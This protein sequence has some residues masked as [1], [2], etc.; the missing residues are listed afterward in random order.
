MDATDP[1]NSPE[2][3]AVD[4]A[5]VEPSARALNPGST[6]AKSR[7]V[8]GECRGELTLQP[9]EAD[10]I[11]QLLS[12][13]NF[14]FL[15]YTPQPES[16][17]M[18]RKPAEYESVRALSERGVGSGSFESRRSK[19]QFSL[20]S[21]D[22]RED[23]AQ[24]VSSYDASEKRS[25]RKRKQRVRYYEE[26]A[27]DLTDGNYRELRHEKPP[28]SQRE[29]LK[30]QHSGSYERQQSQQLYRAVPILSRNLPKLPKDTWEYTAY[31][32]LQA[33]K[34]MDTD[35][36]FWYPVD[37]VADGVP[38]YP[39]IVHTPM[40]FHTITE[41]LHM[42]QYSNPF[43]FQCDCRQIFFNAFLFYQPDNVIWQ[44]AEHLAKILEEK[45]SNTRYLHPDE[46]HSLL[47][48]GED[49]MRATL[50]EYNEATFLRKNKWNSG[51]LGLDDAE[52]MKPLEKRKAAQNH[53]SKHVIDEYMYTGDDDD[54][55]FNELSSVASA[56]DFMLPMD[57]GRG[58]PKGFKKKGSHSKPYGLNRKHKFGD[59]SEE[60]DSGQRVKF[61]GDFPVPEVGRVLPPPPPA[62][63][64]MQKASPLDK[65]ITPSQTRTLHV[66][67][68]RLA[69]NQRKAA[70]ELIEDDLGILGETFMHD[71]TFTFDPSLLPVD[72]QRR[73]F[74][75][76]NA[77]V[78]R[79]IEEMHAEYAR[80]K[81]PKP[82]PEIAIHD[83]KEVVRQNPSEIFDASSSSSSISDVASNF[84]SSDDF[85]DSSDDEPVSVNE[86]A[87]QRV[88]DD[89]PL[90]E[91]TPV[92][93][94]K[95]EKVQLT[96]GIMG[97]HADFFTHVESPPLNDDGS[98]GQQGKKSAWMEWKGQAIH[99][100]TVAQENGVEPLS[101][102]EKIAE[103]FDARI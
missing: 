13:E 47:Q 86:E 78:K 70:L 97:D 43:A 82:Q 18:W 58:R 25:L 20:K 11:N 55:S 96:R 75:Y 64:T 100:G 62:L 74:L 60:S 2:G 67:L 85:F 98:Q 6:V 48:K 59:A 90:P 77:M 46:F 53:R 8:V 4:G 76:V 28:K 44:A 5:T 103:S 93:E 17:K 57:G 3:E 39:K 49:A 19:S 12:Q 65:G 10:R 34:Y 40:D 88:P 29:G 9:D 91:Y 45:L 81:K 37:P 66:N 24:T 51:S 61:V 21:A 95:S 16:S 42:R 32:M 83:A 31:R 22:S 52:A 79:N 63:S 30:K 69:P 102:D 41:R 35:K 26:F 68:S 73:V 92:D 50:L 38:N 87:K 27:Q 99:H 15:V 71:R 101:V 7:A 80:R 94:Q 89:A 72:K 36:W 56:D 1:I 33:I 84:L 14:R 54:D 23:D